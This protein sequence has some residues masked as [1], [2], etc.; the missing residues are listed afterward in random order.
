MS[1][2]D[3]LCKL[4]SDTANREVGPADLEGKSLIEELRLSSVDALEVL[5]KV[6]GEFDIIID[7]DDLSLDMLSSLSN[8]S[9]YITGKLKYSEPF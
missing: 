3:K 9:N 5:I 4:L 6:E 1:I 7:D 2:E 8:L